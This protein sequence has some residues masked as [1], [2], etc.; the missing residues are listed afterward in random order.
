MKKAKRR[1]KSVTIDDTLEETVDEIISQKSPQ[2]VAVDS[3][4]NIS[5][6]EPGELSSDVETKTDLTEDEIKLH[7]VVE[8]I[9]SLLASTSEQFMQRNIIGDLVTKKERKSISKHRQSRK[10]IV[11]LARW[12]DMQMMGYPGMPPAGGV[13]NR[14]SFIGRLFGRRRRETGGY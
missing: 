13:Q 7:T 14:P 3:L 8:T 5:V 11:E 6:S 2:A 1:S 9:S 12:P 10:E 4:I